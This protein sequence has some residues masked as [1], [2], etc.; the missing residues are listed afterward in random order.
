MW[1]RVLIRLGF[2]HEDLARVILTQKSKFIFH[3]SQ[4]YGSNMFIS[5]L[6]QFNLVWNSTLER[7]LE[8]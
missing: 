1:I 4:F 5:L 6:F 2:V 7:A 3:L 8:E